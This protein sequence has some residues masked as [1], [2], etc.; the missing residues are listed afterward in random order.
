MSNFEEIS[1]TGGINSDLKRNNIIIIYLIL[2]IITIVVMI[3]TALVFYYHHKNQETIQNGI[4]IKGIEVSSLTKQE[5]ISKVEAGIQEQMGEH[6]IL[7][8]KN[9]EYYVEPE[10]FNTSFDIY[11]AVEYAYNIGRT[12]DIIQDIKDYSGVLFNNIN[13]EPNLNYD[14]DALKFYLE[15]IQEQLPDQLE[16][17]SY[18]VDG[19]DLIITAGKN[20]AVIYI[21]KLEKTIIEAI[22]TL[23]FS[24]KVYEIPTYALYP[25]KIDVQA[26]HNDIYQEMQNAYYTTEPYMIYAEKEGVDFSV[27]DTEK[28]IEENPNEYEY[29]IALNIIKPEI[30]INDIGIEAFPDLLGTYST[31]YVNNAN[32]TTNLR[33]A[34]S[35]I[36]STVIM[37]GETF[38]FNKVVGQ[39]TRAA[40]YKDAAIFVNGK[41]EDGLAGGICQISTTLYNAVTL[42]NL[43]VTE[44]RNH[45]LLTSYSQP[46]RD[47][48]VV[49]G[50]S[51]LKFVNDRNY[52]V[53]LYFSVSD[54]YAKCSV[55]GLKTD[56]EYDISFETVTIK[57]TSTTM[58]VDTYLIYKQNGTI[59]KKEKLHRDTYKV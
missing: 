8:Y 46:G 56:N 16:Q 53:K 39:R 43:D 12:G 32:R 19:K 2:I 44:R 59:V 4:F 47:A 24:N 28:Y 23:S 25:D 27:E 11:S 1:S 9:H 40:G 10:Q 22:T 31:K 17:S 42:A 38:S 15:G 7:K 57:R 37:P 3:C 6:I 58:I 20:G 18:Y 36:N 29:K 14:K 54:G 48:T 30:T 51:D 45:S 41:T 52:P 55:Y 21:E 50:S 13:I 35:K 34:A 5:A 26:I 33:I 49:W